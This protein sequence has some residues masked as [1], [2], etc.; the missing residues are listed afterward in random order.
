MVNESQ[1]LEF[2]LDSMWPVECEDGAPAS[3]AS[4]QEAGWVEGEMALF[5]P[6]SVCP[7]KHPVS[8]ALRI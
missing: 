4:G 8:E 1:P 5:Y 3:D 2:D 6:V 7:N